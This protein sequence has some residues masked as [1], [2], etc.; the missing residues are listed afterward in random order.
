MY[1]SGA[2]RWKSQQTQR[3][4]G[5]FLIGM[6][7]I[8]SK[9]NKQRKQPYMSLR[10]V[11]Y[12]AVFKQKQ[13]EVDFNA[14]PT[15]FGLINAQTETYTYGE[16]VTL[17]AAPL[18]GKQF[19]EWVLLENLSLDDHADHYNP[20]ANFKVLGN[21]KVQ[22]NFSKIELNLDISFYSLDQNNQEIAGDIGASVS[23]PDIIYHGDSVSLTLT[24]FTGYNFLHWVDL[25]SGEI[26]TTQ[27]S[28]FPQ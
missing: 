26:L 21:A 2:M 17:S 23:H 12:A 4:T 18:V 28:F 14:S 7:V 25:D 5:S 3:I 19:N 1:I 22:A 11:I 20:T 24:P 8:T 9:T 15:E 13:Y 10:T 6:E 27:E 16:Y